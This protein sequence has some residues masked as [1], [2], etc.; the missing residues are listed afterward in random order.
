MVLEN[1]IDAI[2]AV[3][4]DKVSARLAKEFAARMAKPDADIVKRR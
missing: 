2:I 1:L 3:K 4:K